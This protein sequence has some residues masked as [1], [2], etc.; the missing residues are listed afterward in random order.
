[1]SLFLVSVS[2]PSA[3]SRRSSQSQQKSTVSHAVTNVLMIMGEHGCM[4]AS[5]DSFRPDV[6]FRPTQPSSLS[7]VS[8]SVSGVR[9]H[10]QTFLPGPHVTVT[11][12]VTVT[13]SRHHRCCR[14]SSCLSLLEAS[15]RS[16]MNITVC[17]ICRVFSANLRMYLH[18]HN[19]TG[20]LGFLHC[21]CTG[22]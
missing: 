11:V 22:A 18:R 20:M 6:H 21:T 7:P 4:A 12:A 2:V 1:M 5:V 8:V 10:P 3:D 9:W 15:Y 19:T 13:P 17:I 16:S 14:V